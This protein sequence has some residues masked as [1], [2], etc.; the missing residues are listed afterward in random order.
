MALE[1]QVLYLENRMKVLLDQLDE[2][3]ATVFKKET[4][5]NMHKIQKKADEDH[6]H[7]TNIKNY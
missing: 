1:R 3:K 6:A 4:R 5:R 2:D 7:A